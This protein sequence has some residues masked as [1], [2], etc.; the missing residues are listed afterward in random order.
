MACVSSNKLTAVFYFCSKDM[1]I[2]RVRSQSTSKY[3][4]MVVIHPSIDQWFGKRLAGEER[5]KSNIS[6]IIKVR[7]LISEVEKWK[8]G[9]QERTK[10]GSWV[11]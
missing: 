10:A 8:V 1:Q 11:L 9:E 5:R 7:F 2:C 4:S 6:R 3:R